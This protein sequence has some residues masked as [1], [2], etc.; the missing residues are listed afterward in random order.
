M[1]ENAV[2]VKIGGDASGA[3][4]AMRQAASAV[5]S[6]VQQMQ[7]SLKSVAETT[8]ESMNQMK[9]AMSKVHESFEFVTKGFMAFQALSMGGSAF[10]EF[11]TDA[12]KATAQAVSL[13]KSLGV[14]ATEASIFGVALDD[15]HVSIDA[16]AMAGKR[17]AMGLNKNE[18]AF[19]A[20]GVATRDSTGHFR[21]SKDIM[22][23]VNDALKQFKEGTDRNVEGV[24]IY[25][26][27]WTEIAPTLKLTREK[28][29]EVEQKAYDLNL[30][31]GKES[32]DAWNKYRDAQ[33]D[34]SDVMEGFNKTVGEYILPTLT[35]FG[36]WMNEIGPTVIKVTRVAME[37]LVTVQSA[38]ADA[39]KAMWETLVD[40]CAAIF[41]AVKDVFGIGG[42][43]ITGMEFFKNLVRLVEL[44]FIAMRTGIEVGSA[45]IVA[46]IKDLLN[47]WQTAAAIAK[48]VFGGICDYLGIVVTAFTTLSEVA[49]KALKFDFSGAIDAAS[50]GARQ[51]ADK[52][53]SAVKHIT[54]GIPDAF[55]AGADRAGKIAEEANAKIVA[56]AI[57]G[58]EDMMNA[59]TGNLGGARSV[60]KPTTNKDGKS[61]TGG[62]GE[63]G[64]SKQQNRMALWEAELAKEKSAY[65]ERNNMR[66]MSLAEEKEYWDKVA[67]YAGLSEKE[68]GA[69]AKKSAELRL[70][71]LKKAAADEKALTQEGIDDWK[72]RALEIVDA[73]KQ[74]AQQ[75]FA[76][77]EITN[78]QLLTQEQDFENRRFEIERTALELRKSLIDPT[79]DPVEYQKICDKLLAIER[80]H[81][82]DMKGLQ[83]KIALDKAQPGLNVFKSMQTSFEG[84]ITGMLTKAMTFRQALASI[85]KA[86][87]TAFIQ[88]IVA[89]PTA[90]F[91]AGLAKQLG[92]QRVF[93]AAKTAIS[94][95]F[96]GIRTLL[97][98][99][100]TAE[101]VAAKGAEATAVISADAGEAAAG[102]AASQAAIPIIG[103]GLAA[104]AF[105]GTMALVLGAKSLVSARGG[106]DIPAGVNPLTQLHEKEMVLPAKYAEPLRNMADGGGG[107]SGGGV[108]MHVHTQSVQDFTSFLKKN[109]HAIGPAV[110]RASRN[111]APTSISQG[112]GKVY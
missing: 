49:S 6:A 88:E 55:K 74:E 52:A 9:E 28:L 109:S 51:I 32:I 54:T 10:K 40:A 31:V 90:E 58:R 2:E 27:A 8:K 70:Q 36:E 98:G 96:S 22:L 107:P 102:A 62:D 69:V 63:D 33:N 105:A 73:D 24:K 19:K 104:A 15:V 94:K 86:T 103:P 93:E 92:M 46:C 39:A 23:D 53:L 7:N 42:E 81:Q 57:K 48:E 67:G 47:I 89:K 35:R 100:E 64:K 66:E 110:R 30:V 50:N 65:M 26:R 77:G 80:K 41:S 101:A 106:F 13:G 99:A 11:V 1:S 59:L 44:A 79:R 71:I 61:S 85:W 91:A 18:D 60:T 20:L 4:D 68:K 112:L 75:R 3:T 16:V 5:S 76:L 82:A 17:I 78:A 87:S 95:M 45:A 12:N 37:G 25:G 83:N 72:M 21:N 56:S 29:D 97:F 34:I 43:T 111:F 38:V 84:A 14:N 108:H